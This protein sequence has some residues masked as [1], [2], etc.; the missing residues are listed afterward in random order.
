M[1][2]APHTTH[3]R[4]C[5][6]AAAPWR[7]TMGVKGKAAAASIVVA[8]QPYMGLVTGA[9]SWSQPEFKT[10]YP[11]S[12]WELYV[13]P[14]PTELRGAAAMTRSAHAV[15][16]TAGSSGQLNMEPLAVARC[17][18]RCVFGVEPHT[19]GRG[20][21]C[22]SLCVWCTARCVFGVEPHTPGRGSLCGS[23]CVWCT[24]RLAVCLA[25][26]HQVRQHAAHRLPTVRAETDQTD[27]NFTFAKQTPTRPC[28]C[29]SGR[30]THA[31]R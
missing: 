17:V 10:A 4:A 29:E 7:L 8:S 25:W 24:V 28:V 5:T 18:A 31:Q 3:T 1:Y 30:C 21:L 6:G 15:C 16:G 9:T 23:P 14:L 26:R 27:Q 12:C 13:S 2:H 19:P 11:G 22:G 20:S